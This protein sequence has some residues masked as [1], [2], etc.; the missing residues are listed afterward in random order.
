MTILTRDDD[1]T[2][3][4]LLQSSLCVGLKFSPMKHLQIVSKELER[5]MSGRLAVSLLLQTVHSYKMLQY[6]TVFVFV[7]LAVVNK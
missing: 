2:L 3:H 1:H 5:S 7:I 4:K 6:V